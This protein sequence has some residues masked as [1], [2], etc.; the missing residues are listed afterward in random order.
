[1]GSICGKLKT[2]YI[3]TS[4]VTDNNNPPLIEDKNTYE[5]LSFS[6]SPTKFWNV[7]L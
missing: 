5:S 1:M 3:H 7:V 2:K 6:H 4:T